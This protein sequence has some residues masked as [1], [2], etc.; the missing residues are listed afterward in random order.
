MSNSLLSLETQ[1]EPFST[2][3]WVTVSLNPELKHFEDLHILEYIKDSLMKERA[4]VDVYPARQPYVYSIMVDIEESEGVSQSIEKRAIVQAI[5]I[6][7][8]W[9][10]AERLPFIRWDVFMKEPAG[11][12]SILGF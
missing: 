3:R 10:A 9:I 7:C 4:W 11:F 1:N 12:S 2:I 6:I 8:D 5:K